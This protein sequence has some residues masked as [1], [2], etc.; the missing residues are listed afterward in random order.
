MS[1]RFLLPQYKQGH[2]FSDHAAPHRPGAAREAGGREEQAEEG[3]GRW[4]ESLSWL[5][6]EQREGGEVGQTLQTVAARRHAA[7]KA[8]R[9]S[10]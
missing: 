6:V 10:R 2:A 7:L 5:R 4:G 8:S 9:Q 3:R 1:D